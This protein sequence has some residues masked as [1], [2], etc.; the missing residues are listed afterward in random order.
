MADTH[1]GMERHTVG[2]IGGAYQAFLWV[3]DIEKA[4]V[5]KLVCAV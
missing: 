4:V 5:A 1:D 2:K 3:E